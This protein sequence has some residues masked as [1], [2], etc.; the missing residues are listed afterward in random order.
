MAD[1]FQATAA[2][3]SRGLSS[4]RWRPILLAGAAGIAIS[5]VLFFVVRN[6]EDRR[7]RV[8]LQR[9]AEIPAGVL[10]RDLS[11]YLHLLKSIDAFYFSSR[12]VD[13]AEFSGFTR[14]ALARLN[15]ILT[16]EWIPRVMDASRSAH[17][18]AAR[19]EGFPLYQIVERDGRGQLTR[20]PQ[21]RG[22]LPIYYCEPAERR[23]ELGLDLSLARG[24][25]EA[26]AWAR[27][28]PQPFAGVPFP[29]LAGTNLVYRCRIF[30]GVFT[31]QV[32]HATPAERRQNLA[33]F[34]ALSLDLSRVVDGSLRQ[35]KAAEVKGLTWQLI[36]QTTDRTKPGNAPIRLHQ[37]SEW[38]AT[39]TPDIEARIRFA[40]AG[41]DWVLRC[42]PTASYL[43]EGLGTGAWCVLVGGLVL[44]SLLLAYLSAALGRTARVEKL[45]VERTTALA[46]SNEDLR[47]EI[48]RR[49][50]METALEKEQDLIAALL[51]TIPDHIYFKDLQSRF[52]RINRAMAWSFKLC[53][54][55]EAVGRTDADFFS[56]EH[57]QRALA[58]EQE[59]I[60]TGRPM[61]AREEKETWPDGSTT[62]VSST[63]QCL[64]DKSGTVVGTFG[65][66][67]DVTLRKRVERRLSVQYM[68]A[69]VLAESESFA[70]T[71]PQVLQEVGECLGWGVGA[72]WLVEPGSGTLRCSQF[73]HAPHVAVP[74]FEAASRGLTL[75][76]GHG[77]PGRVL[78]TGEPMWIRDVVM[79]ENFPRAALALEEGLHG[80]FGFPIRS[81]SGG[82]G[83]IE[84]FSARIEQ[85]DE[86]WLRMFAAIGSQIGQFIERKRMEEALADKARELERSNQELEQFAYVASHDLQEPLRMISSYTQLLARRY[87]D[88]LDADGHEFVKFA[89]DGATRMQA[90]INDLLTYSRVGT[91]AKAFAA[92][93]TAEVMQR[94]LKNLEVAIQESQ[95]RITVDQLPVVTGD[96]TQLTQ[97]FQ[98]LV[99]NAIKFRGEPPPVIRISAFRATNDG[100]TCWQFAVRDQGIGIESQHFER[101]FVIFQRLHSRDEY[102][103]TGIGLAVCK[104]IVERHGGQIWVESKPGAGTIFHFTLRE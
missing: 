31:N 42:R 1:P 99:G 10:Q 66:S 7:F 28:Y 63:K 21:R 29:R 47:G 74:K 95:A 27:D 34:A 78:A 51:D 48:H 60:R 38:L 67:R 93:D 18:A 37:S 53:S 17:E 72:M 39:D 33:G 97:L 57:A 75:A 6:V 77:L 62:W 61:V 82:L 101:I 103:G 76:A 79:D 49:E 5:C 65:I 91:K 19:T 41:R 14:D 56:G 46:L 85:P 104:K 70:A 20:A 64:R 83:V 98:N 96:A 71:A 100:P 4:G 43:S 26:M 25:L 90:L 3:P 12:S 11:D 73:W 89:V 16:A 81:A 36:D 8:E 86:E 52:L 22:Y 9:R 23:E 92:V 13:R 55:E 59:I 87:A 15:G 94:V 44:T 35:L 54:A 80:A 68:V 88:K 2:R 58:D 30:A 45:V 40:M 102:P 50:E 24:D 69:R 32:A 84:F